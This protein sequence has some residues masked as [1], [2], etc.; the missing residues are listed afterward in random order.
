MHQV[1]QGHPRLHLAFEA[2]QNALR[3]IQRHNA[4]G[5]GKSHQARAR[6]EADTDR[7]TRVAVAA[8]ADCVRQEHAVE[9]T[10]N[11]AIAWAQRDAAAV[12]HEVRQLVVHLHIDWF[13]VSRCVAERLH[14]QV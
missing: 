2:H 7:E 12:A 3:H 4:R 14:D 1:A 8:R 11:N 10:V 5:S 9:P 6:R 13:W